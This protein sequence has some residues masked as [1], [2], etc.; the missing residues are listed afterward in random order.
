MGV[1]VRM[2][3]VKRVAGR[4]RVQPAAPGPFPATIHRTMLVCK[5][6]PLRSPGGSLRDRSCAGAN[7]FAI[8]PVG[9]AFG[10]APPVRSRARVTVEVCFGRPGPSVALRT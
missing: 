5:T 7:R 6:G 9:L 10:F 1:R 3:R 4:M 2:V 8:F